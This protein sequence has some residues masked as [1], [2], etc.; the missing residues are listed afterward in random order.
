MD[1]NNSNQKQETEKTKP[2]HYKVWKRQFI[3]CFSFHTLSCASR[4]FTSL[5]ESIKGSLVCT[6]GLRSALSSPNAPEH[7]LG[8]WNHQCRWIFLHI[9]IFLAPPR[10]KLAAPAR[11]KTGIE[12]NSWRVKWRILV[13]SSLNNVHTALIPL[14]EPSVLIDRNQWRR[15]SGTTSPSGVIVR[16][17]FFRLK[18][19]LHS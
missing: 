13:F 1:G 18:V 6:Y 4:V 11:Q 16:L 9:D 8:S 2:P 5:I 14:S 3:N 15:N 12:L 10:D 19:N 17:V 7:I